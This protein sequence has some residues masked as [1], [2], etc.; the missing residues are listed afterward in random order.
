MKEV[1]DP[2]MI[3]ATSPVLFKN[4]LWDDMIQ[5]GQDFESF[6]LI[7]DLTMA[8]FL[9]IVFILAVAINIILKLSDCLEQDINR[10]C[11]Y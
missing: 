8:W 1:C 5:C 7:W 2:D 6:A 10:Y 9:C 11:Q 4:L 3:P